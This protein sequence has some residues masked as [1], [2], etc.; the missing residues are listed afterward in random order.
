M[1]MKTCKWMTAM[2]LCAGFSLSACTSDDGLNSPSEAQQGTLMLKLSSGT[3]FTE[4]TRAVNEE[5]YKNTGN[6]T[7]QVFD[8]DEIKRLECLGSQLEQNLPLTLSIGSYTVKAFYG[9]EQAASRDEFYVE[10]SAGGTVKAGDKNDPITVTCSPTCGR[11]KVQFEG[12]DEYFTDYDVTFGGTTALG[13][14]TISWAKADTE[15]WYVKLA[16]NGEKINFTIAAEAKEGY[17]SVGE[18]KGSFSLLRNKAYKMKVIP[19]YNPPGTGSIDLEIT[20]DESTNDI[21]KDI[22]VPITWI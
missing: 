18:W 19:G 22:E 13:T 20:I 6:Y 21:K 9:T 10:G 11:I 15:P 2:M 7:V 5:A 8:K 4:E 17:N 3:N 16:E 14:R 12:M 1:A